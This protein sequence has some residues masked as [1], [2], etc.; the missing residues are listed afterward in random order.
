MNIRQIPARTPGWIAVFAA[1]V[2]VLN[3]LLWVATPAYGALRIPAFISLIEAQALGA[4]L[5]FFFLKG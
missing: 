3:L 4:L 5:M 2:F 1:L